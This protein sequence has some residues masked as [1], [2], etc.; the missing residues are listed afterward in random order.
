[1]E[2]TPKSTKTPTIPL[3]FFRTP[4]MDREFKVYDS[5]CSLDILEFQKVFLDHSSYSD[6]I[7]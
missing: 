5:C 2:K 6:N 1:M 7:L 4:I 3:V